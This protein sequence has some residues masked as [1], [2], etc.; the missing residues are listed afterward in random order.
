MVVEQ[1]REGKCSLAQF[2]ANKGT[3]AVEEVIELAKE[4][5]QTESLYLCANKMRIQLLQEESAHE[6]AAGCRGKWLE[7]ADQRFQMHG[8]LK[9]EFCSAVYNALSEARGKYR[10]IF[11]YR[12]NK[13]REV[14]YPISLKGHL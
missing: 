7:A 6:C 3:K 10:N 2:I 8:I 5:S 13:L 4:F 1:N 9:E 11:I 14:I 12:K